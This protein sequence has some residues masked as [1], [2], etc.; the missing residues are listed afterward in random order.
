MLRRPQDLLNHQHCE[1]IKELASLILSRGERTTLHRV[2]GHASIIGNEKAGE[3]A[4]G[5]ARGEISYEECEM[6]ETPSNLRHTQYWP[7]EIKWNN[8]WTRRNGQRQLIDRIE[9][10]ATFD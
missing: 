5:A 1:L 7:Y 6:Y 9:A 2:K 4:K 10:G 3:I 8:H